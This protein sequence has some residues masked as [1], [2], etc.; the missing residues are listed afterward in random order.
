MPRSAVF[1]V[2]G[3]R[4]VYVRTA[5]G[6]E[7]REIKLVAFTESLAVI[8]G[9]EA[10]AEVALVNPNAAADATSPSAPGASL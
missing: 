2:A 4:S 9:V 3:K 6:F 7:A 5:T 8:D 10:G 1:E